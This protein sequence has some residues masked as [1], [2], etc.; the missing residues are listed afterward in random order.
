MANVSCSFELRPSLY[1]VSNVV[2]MMLMMMIMSLLL[3]SSTQSPTRSWDSS[4]P[5]STSRFTFN[6][7]LSL[8][9]KQILTE[10]E[11][12]CVWVW[13]GDPPP[14]L[15][16]L[17]LKKSIIYPHLL[18]TFSCLNCSV[19]TMDLNDNKKKKNQEKSFFATSGF[20]PFPSPSLKLIYPSKLR[21]RKNATLEYVSREKSSAGTISSPRGAQWR[22]R[23]SHI[24]LL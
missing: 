24:N 1:W 15:I 13:K 18:A 12:E 7:T 16:L 8:L 22:R 14:P 20:F 6:T 19:V 23:K 5:L 4:P 17:S 9:A 21:D 3:L 2:M 10:R 11:R